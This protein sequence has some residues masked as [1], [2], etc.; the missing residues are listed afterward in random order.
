MDATLWEHPF[1]ERAVTEHPGQRSWPSKA[2]N[3]PPSVSSAMEAAM[4]KKKIV[5][6]G[7]VVL[8]AVLAI[9]SAERPVPHVDAI[10]M[11]PG[12]N[13]VAVIT[14]DGRS[15]PVTFMVTGVTNDESTQPVPLRR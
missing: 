9:G 7:L 12:P 4:N 14:A 8:V 11:Q 13:Q 10:S 1:I 6:A 3:P 15:N 5:K 2:P